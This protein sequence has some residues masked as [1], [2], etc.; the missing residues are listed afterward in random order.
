MQS[1]EYQ[2]IPFLQKN[3]CLGGTMAV[4]NKSIENDYT[5]YYYDEKYLP[6]LKKILRKDYTIDT[7][8]MLKKTA[9]TQI[10]KIDNKKY[11]LKEIHKLPLS[12]RFLSI[13]RKS[14]C[15]E[16]LI[17]TCK[18][19]EKGFTELGEVYG[20][21]EVRNLFIK[22]Q[23]LIMEFIDGEI[24]NFETDFKKVED[25]LLKLHKARSYHGD[26]HAQN[27][28]IDKDNNLRAIDTRL[29]NNYIGNIGGHLDMHKFRRTFGNQSPYPY[30]KDIFYWY[31][32]IREVKKKIVD[33]IKGI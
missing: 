19:R 3:L 11:V 12:K 1:I 8:L 20:I 30:K 33:W 9:D 27:F 14:H 24:L 5:L 4:L 29:K 16:V 26:V 6:L 13:F 10:I 23:F 21:G 28:L 17:N 22:Q 31:C 15:L 7:S 25:F 2:G 18:Y 32:K